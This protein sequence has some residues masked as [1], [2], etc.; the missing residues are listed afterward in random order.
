MLVQLPLFGAAAT[1]WLH[2]IMALA[3]RLA[4]NTSP[5]DL[6]PQRGARQELH[7]LV[8]RR[9]IQA[10]LV[11]AAREHLKVACSTHRPLPVLICGHSWLVSAVRLLYDRHSTHSTRPKSA[12]WPKLTPP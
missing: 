6:P 8:H 12:T 4:L 5:P 9:L 7:R 3:I 2:R 1:K 11:R 10:R